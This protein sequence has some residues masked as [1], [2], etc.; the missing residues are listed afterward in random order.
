MSIIAKDGIKSI[1][2][3]IK[4]QKTFGIPSIKSLVNVENII[5]VAK[6]AVSTTKDT[7]SLFKKART[8]A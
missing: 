3:N 7:M 8:N 1:S 5:T 2:E 6:A 4:I